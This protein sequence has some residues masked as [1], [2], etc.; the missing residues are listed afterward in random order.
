MN[1]ENIKM[2]FRNAENY[3]Q[4]ITNLYNEA[5]P[6]CEKLPIKFLFERASEGKAAFYAIFD[7][8]NVFVG[9]I[10]V[11]L[12]KKL[13]CLYY[14][15][16]I[17][18]KRNCGYGRKTLDLLRKT[19]AG[20]A[21]VLLIEN[22]A[23]TSSVNYEQRIRRLHFYEANGYKQLH[24]NINEAGVDYELLGTENTITRKEYML[25]LKNYFGTE[26]FKVMYK[27]EMLYTD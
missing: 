16:V 17:K 3:E 8:D 9:L 7:N 10:Y 20:R 23:D 25:A 19:Y 14:F 15:A 21:I 13:V 1:K 26:L 24:I 12:M 2:E 5:F 27:G 4:Q 6:Q 22:T 18:N 11:I